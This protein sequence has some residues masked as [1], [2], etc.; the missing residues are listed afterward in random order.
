MFCFY[1][2][3]VRYLSFL[4]WKMHL[5]STAEIQTSVHTHTHMQ[6]T[7]LYTTRPYTTIQDR[8]TFAK[9]LPEIHV[10][11]YSTSICL[12]NFLLRVLRLYEWT[13]YFFGAIFLFFF[14]LLLIH[15]SYQAE[16]FTKKKRNNKIVF[17]CVVVVVIKMLNLK[18]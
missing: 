18:L 13:K 11:S 16:I 4:G 9:G 15:S 17:W 10:V 7:K 8:A 2:F 5:H 1:I 14:L 3:T 6:T 12:V